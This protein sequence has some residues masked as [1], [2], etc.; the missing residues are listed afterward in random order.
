[1]KDEPVVFIVLHRVYADR[2]GKMTDIRE[3]ALRV[4]RLDAFQESDIEGVGC[5]VHWSNGPPHV[6]LV[7]ETM[8]EVTTLL[9]QARPPIFDATYEPA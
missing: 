8:E 4:H 1:V 3:L 2:D 9:A 7:T 6:E 5:E